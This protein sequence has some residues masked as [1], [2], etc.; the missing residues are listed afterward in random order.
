MCALED[1]R[2]NE[3]STCLRGGDVCIWDDVR[4]ESYDEV[5][6]EFEYVESICRID[7]TLKGDNTNP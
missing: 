1:I 7:E 3:K 4:C 6:Y 5:L 2:Q